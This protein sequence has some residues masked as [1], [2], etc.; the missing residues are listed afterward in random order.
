[1]RSLIHWGTPTKLIGSVM[2]MRSKTDRTPTCTAALADELAAELRSI[3][4][5][6]ACLNLSQDTLRDFLDRTTVT[7]GQGDEALIS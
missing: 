5:K 7:A 3:E 2:Q 1:M 4:D 6:I